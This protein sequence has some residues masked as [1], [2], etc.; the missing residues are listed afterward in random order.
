[1]SNIPARLIEMSRTTK[2]AIQLLVDGTLIVLCF[3]GAMFLRLESLS[4][5]SDPG[6]WLS[7]GI[8]APV[9]LLIFIRL[10]LYRSIVRH[11]SAE[12]LAIVGGGVI[13]SGVILFATSQAIG[14]PVPRSVSGIYALLLLFCV[15]G[16]RFLMRRLLR[17][18]QM[19]GRK[20]VLIYGAGESGRQ[21]L[22][23]LAQGR[24]FAPV[25]FVDDNVALQRTLIG[26]KRV[27]A[28]NDIPRLIEEKQISVILMAMPSASRSRRRE[29]FE[30]LSPLGLEIRTIPGLEDIV[31]GRAS[32]SDLKRVS[33]EDMLGRD[34]VPPVP[35]LM[36]ANITGK[37][38]LVS[39]AGG[40]IGSELCRQIIQHDPAALILLEVSEFG[41][42]TISMELR[43]SL[44]AKGQSIRIEPVLGSVQNP[45]RVRTILRAFGVQTVYH[46]AAYK[47]VVMVEENVVEGIRNNVFGTR[48]IAEA[49]A[50]LGVEHFILI[51]TDKAVRPT[52]FMGASKRMAELVC[53]ALAKKHKRTTFSMVRF[54][55]VLGSSGS[56]IPRFRAQIEAGGPL[57]VTHRD[58]TRY[59]MTIPEAAQLVIQAGAMAKGGEV[60]VLDMGEPVKIM[61]LARNMIQLYG[62]K[63]YVIDEAGPLEPQR[64]DIGIKIVGL[65]KGEKLYEELL[66]GENPSGTLHPR[67]LCATETALEQEALDALLE[68]L[69]RACLAFDI[70]TIRSIFLEAPLGYRPNDTEL[71][72]LI[73][74]AKQQGRPADARHLSVVGDRETKVRG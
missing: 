2:R 50:E 52:N 11:I 39:G 73:W 32:F 6:V 21:L 48:V 31:S 60:F 26:G 36:R 69:L 49:A 16:V 33:P 57:T 30:Q 67:I 17:L 53:Q 22:N 14:A 59:F 40:S 12:A 19:K 18:P 29:I 55:N 5:M 15:G 65:A 44:A 25:A 23:A 35:G 42:Y 24:E 62:L 72:D 8:V 13:V 54:G 1:M 46:A 10:G 27:F 37:V 64:G 20:S 45:G 56:V 74:L 38:V 70:A 61:D 43:E 47:H 58:I 68:R 63:P 51:S 41:L 7:L 28:A 34:P 3:W 66:I 9:T 4:G 71:H